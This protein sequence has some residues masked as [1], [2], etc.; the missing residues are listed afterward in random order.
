MMKSK[1]L[2]SFLICFLLQIFCNLSAMNYQKPLVASTTFGKMPY[3]VVLFDLRRY[4]AP[5][6]YKQHEVPKGYV[7]KL[8]KTKQNDFIG[9]FCDIQKIF[10]SNQNYDPITIKPTFKVCSDI[11]KKQKSVEIKKRGGYVIDEKRHL[12]YWVDPYLVPVALKYDGKIIHK[13]A[14]LFDMFPTQIDKE[15][16]NYGI[17]EMIDHI[18]KDN[19]TMEVQLQIT[20]FGGIVTEEFSTLG[21][22]QYT[23]S[24]SSKKWYHRYFKSWTPYY[25]KTLSISDTVPLLR[26]SLRYMLDSFTKKTMC[27][28]DSLI[29]NNFFNDHQDFDNYSQSLDK[30]ISECKD[31]YHNLV[32]CDLAD[33][34]DDIN[35]I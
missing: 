8:D 31:K 27:D 26:A 17:C 13:K 2:L 23:Y 20:I 35:I 34:I 25:L 11:N 15:I 28:D 10:P 30:A 5:Y 32:E 6:L 18:A 4:I 21:F 3:R 14:N 33:E 22:F 1:F 7:F 19:V 12:K 29:L 16:L 24:P 9:T